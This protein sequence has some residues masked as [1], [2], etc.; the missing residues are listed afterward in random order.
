MQAGLRREYRGLLVEQSCG[1]VVCRPYHKFFNVF[2]VSENRQPRLKVKGATIL[3]KLGGMMIH[4]A[5]I[6]GKVIFCSKG[7]HPQRQVFQHAKDVW[8]RTRGILRG[9]D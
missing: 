2:E 9:P 5:V 8:I 3:E 1:R 7:G 6:G 4:G